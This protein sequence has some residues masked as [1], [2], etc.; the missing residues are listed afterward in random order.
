MVEIGTFCSQCTFFN[1]GD[2]D[3]NLIKKWESLGNVKQSSDSEVVINRI[4]MYRREKEWNKDL[5]IEE[6]I[7][8]VKRDVY[9]K[10]SVIV[11]CKNNDLSGL[12]KTLSKLK[13]VN[14]IERFFPVII[15][16]NTST[17]E[18]VVDIV[19]SHF[20]KFKAM[21]SLEDK[22]T[23][24]MV[25][26]AFRNVKNGFIFVLNASKDF[27]SSIFDNVNT[28]VNIDLKSFVYSQSDDGDF[29]QCIFVAA[30]YKHLGGNKEFGFEQKMSELT[31][32]N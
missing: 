23:N 6:K 9:I 12:D 24:G 26:Q 18:S 27:D 2:C 7:S 15:A 5:S 16:D 25:D 10:G 14:R 30:V 13:T 29:H 20:K 19:K 21:I 32:T 17:L 31:I 4:C 22:S 11:F 28:V 8:H 3:L 1:S